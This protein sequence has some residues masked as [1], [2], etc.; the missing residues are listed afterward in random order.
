MFLQ[1]EVSHDHHVEPRVQS[2]C[3]KAKRLA[4]QG[5]VF[6]TDRGRLAHVLL[7]IEEYQKITA[8]HRNMA[9]ML[10][11][12]ESAEIDFEPTPLQKTLFANV[13]LS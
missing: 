6:I 2:G 1:K 13:D 3:R 9:D 10:G 12:P 7:T 8:T 5:P 11:C 4:M